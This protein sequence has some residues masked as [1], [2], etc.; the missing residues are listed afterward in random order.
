MKIGGSHKWHY[1][2][3]TWFETKLTPNQW[4]FNF[5]SVKTRFN[6]APMDSGAKLNTKYHWY[7][8]ADQLASKLDSNSYITDMKGVKFKL[9][10]KRPNWKKFSY[11]YP[12]QQSYR[13]RVINILERTLENLKNKK[14][15]IEKFIV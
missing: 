8:I 15:G 6:A 1:D 5:H 3:G 11:N 13:D 14:I 2:K 9:G 12:E 4:T 10:H 7:I